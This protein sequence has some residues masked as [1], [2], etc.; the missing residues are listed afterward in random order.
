MFHLACQCHSS[1]S[2]KALPAR[3]LRPLLGTGA[4]LPLGEGRRCKRS[5]K[6]AQDLHAEHISN[7]RSSRRAQ[8]AARGLGRHSRPNERLLG[9][10]KLCSQTTRAAESAVAAPNMCGALP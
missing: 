2:A 1:P 7:E 10:G 9:C 4:G 3:Q 8:A 5:S 6:R